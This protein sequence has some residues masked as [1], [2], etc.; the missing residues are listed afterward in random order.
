MF[1]SVILKVSLQLVN[2]MYLG[3]EFQT[4]PVIRNAVSVYITWS[5]FLE[6][7]SQSLVFCMVFIRPRQNLFVNMN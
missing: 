7:H 5:S 4:R 2:F 3:R 1:K 6:Q